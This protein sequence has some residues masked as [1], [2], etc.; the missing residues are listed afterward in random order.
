MMTMK[1]HIVVTTLFLALVS[2]G[3]MWFAGCTEE[4]VVDI[5]LAME[6]PAPFVQG[7]SEDEVFDRTYVVNLAQAVDE[8]LAGTDYSRADIKRAVLNGAAYGVTKFSHDHDWKIGGKVTIQRTDGTPGPVVE[9]LS[10]KGVSIEESLDEKITAVLDPAGVAVIN[11]AL[12]DLV[13][14]PASAPVLVLVTSNE[15][16]IPA[17][18]VGDAIRFDWVVWVRYQVIAP[19]AFDK[20]DP[21][22]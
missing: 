3:V 20:L 21:W 18:S 17:P 12:E 9:L 22:P 6:F 5:A 1:K 11:A 13:T 7:P 16:V 2:L 14:N 15:S 8:A 4:E 10:Y 19:R